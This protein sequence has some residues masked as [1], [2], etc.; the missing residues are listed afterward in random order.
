MTD[1][2]SK[3]IFVVD[4]EK[5]IAQTV[6]AILRQ[7]GFRTAAFENAQEAIDAASVEA[8]DLMITD[9]VMPGLSGIELAILFQSRWPQCKTLLFSGQAITADLLEDAR[10]SGHQ[11]D[12]LS[13]PIHPSDLLAKLNE[14]A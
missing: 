14:L 9:V 1:N 10:K 2:K 3:Y 5:I 8:P 13:K 7:V 6:A 4:D 12:V 11:F